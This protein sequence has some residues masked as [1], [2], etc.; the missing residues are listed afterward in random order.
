MTLLFN[1]NNFY[2]KLINNSVLT[3]VK[4]II[5]YLRSHKNGVEANQQGASG[6]WKGR[7][8]QSIIGRNTCFTA[9]KIGRF[10]CKYAFSAIDRKVFTC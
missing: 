4:Y 6:S 3:Y 8:L 1:V 5:D 2:N 10:C 7:A 9:N